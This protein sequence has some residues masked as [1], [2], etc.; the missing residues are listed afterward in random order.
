LS[1]ICKIVQKGKAQME[2]AARFFSGYAFKRQRPGGGRTFL[3]RMPADLK[4]ALVAHVEKTGNLDNL[5][6]ARAVLEQR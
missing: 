2:G 4:H 3:A 1:G 6:Q 5:A